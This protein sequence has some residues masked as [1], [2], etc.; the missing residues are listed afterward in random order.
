MLEL[1]KQTRLGIVTIPG[2]NAPCVV[3]CE[4]RQGEVLAVV[5]APPPGFPSSNQPNC[6]RL[7]IWG[8]NGRLRTE[9]N[10]YSDV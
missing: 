6:F 10:R 8:K 9:W 7:W 5:V 1:S 4:G 2:K 3:R